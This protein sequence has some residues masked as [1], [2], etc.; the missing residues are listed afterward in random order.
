MLFNQ[1]VLESDK[2]MYEAEF[3]AHDLPEVSPCSRTTVSWHDW[4]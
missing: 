1:K 2:L 3:E 4:F